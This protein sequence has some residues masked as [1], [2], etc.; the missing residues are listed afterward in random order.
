MS[1]NSKPAQKYARLI[2]K[3]PHLLLVTVLLA[4]L[5]AMS[6][7]TAARAATEGAGNTLDFDGS[8]D[9]VDLTD[10]S[11]LKPTSGLTVEVWAYADDWL[12]GSIQKL[13]S[14]LE[15]TGGYGIDIIDF[16]GAGLTLLKFTAYA[17]GMCTATHFEIGGLSVGWHHI[18]GTYDGVDIRLYVDGAL[19]N[20]SPAG[21]S[22]SYVSNNTLIGADAGSGSTPDG[23][24]FSGK[25]DEVRI[26]N[27]ARSVTDI[28]ANMYK[29]LAGSESGLVAYYKLNETTGDTADNAA[30]E[31]LDGTLKNMDNSDWV[32]SG[33]FA[34]SRNALDFDGSDDYVNLG[35]SGDLKPTSALTV[36]VW[37]YADD[38]TPA[39]T[40]QFIGNQESGGYGIEILSTPTVQFQVYANG[41]W[42]TADYSTSSLAAGWHHIAGTFDGQ[43]TRLYVDGVLRDTDD[44][45]GSYSITYDI[46]NS[47]IIGEE[48]GGGATPDGDNYSGKLD[49]VR[50]WNTARTAAQI[51]DNMFRT[52]DGDETNLQAYYR[53]D[54]VSAAGASP[55]PLRPHQ[56]RQQRYPHRYG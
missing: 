56:Q 52:L 36:E 43:Y 9:C 8:D 22:I 25:L 45:G 21:S 6:P 27:V 17:G 32:T 24:Y 23:E 29:E 7:V 16:Y 10:S 2:N 54:Q 11:A 55:P 4:G 35:N 47:T 44:A 14:N 26:W 49:E 19:R 50:I 48:A 28:Q 42:R 13:I 31:S 37:A 41:D 30:G 34:G 3:A 40:E 1:A 39:G 38:W 5:L 12:P 20:T 18:A 33:A 46:D 15:S 53:F 51:R